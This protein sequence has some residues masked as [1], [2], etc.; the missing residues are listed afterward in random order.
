MR[1]SVALL[2]VAAMCVCAVEARLH[3]HHAQSD[4]QSIQYTPAALADQIHDLP[5]LAVAPGFNMFSGYLTVDAAHNRS[6]FYCQ[7]ASPHKQITKA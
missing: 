4:K 5:G 3:H 1:F 2:L 7:T 6:I